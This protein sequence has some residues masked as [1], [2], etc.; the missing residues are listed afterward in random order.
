MRQ[1]TRQKPWA[2]PAALVFWLL[3][4]QGAALLVNVPVMLPTPRAVASAWAELAATKAF[5]LST[6][7]SLAR[8]MA[9]FALGVLL[10]LLSAGLISAS[11]IADTLLSPL[12]VCIKSTPIASFIM[13][14]WVFVGSANL[15]TLVAALMVLPVVS[16][17]MVEGVRKIDRRLVEVTQVFGFS[18][19]KRLRHLYLPSLLPY[20][21]SAL[22][23]SLGFA[24]KS[25]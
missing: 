4:W 6:L 24:W 22:L 25:G 17:N 21:R 16:A 1:F 8:V 23:T 11:R 18:R 13:L 12:L 10:G 5:Y 2:K 20:V 9:G 3:V 7:Y 19:R 15:P 14:S